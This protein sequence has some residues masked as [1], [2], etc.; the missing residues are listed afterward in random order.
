SIAIFSFESSGTMANNRV[1]D[2]NDAISANWSKG[3][4]FQNNYVT[5]S[6]SGVH[7]DNNGGA[8]GAADVL[9]GKVVVNWPANS[10]GGWGFAPYRNVTVSCNT[11]SN[12]TVGVALAGQQVPVTP[13]FSGNTVSGNLD[14]AGA[15]VY[16]TSSLFG[17][18]SSDVSGAF[19]ENFVSNTAAGFFLES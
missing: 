11:I 16:V 8:G 7:T 17:F 14:P 15:G 5:N 1:S 12:V 2:A 13:V 19:Q 10:Y 9:Q 18:G 6:G 4:T 3:T